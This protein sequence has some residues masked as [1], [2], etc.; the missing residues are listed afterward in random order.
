M[1]ASRSQAALGGT[2][3][4]R[5]VRGKHEDATRTAV[6]TTASKTRRRGLAAPFAR[7]ARRDKS[8][9]ARCTLQ[10]SPLAAGTF[11]FD[12]GERR[13]AA[14]RSLL[15]AARGGARCA[16]R[17]ARNFSRPQFCHGARVERL[18]VAG[19]P[20][21]QR[22]AA[23]AHVRAAEHARAC[24]TR[25]RGP[26]D[27]RQNDRPPPA[28]AAALL[29]AR[30]HLS[31]PRPS[32]PRWLRYAPPPPRASRT[33]TARR[34]RPAPP[35]ATGVEESTAGRRFTTCRGRFMFAPTTSGP[36][37]RGSS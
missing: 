5:V 21:R 12:C 29:Q 23:A 37:T 25:E 20:A 27:P 24:H 4:G 16:A 11:I 28:A 6:K 34:R 26:P 31:L 10:P 13:R 8:F 9:H 32:C 33:S 3:P 18:A 7:H 22:A 36:P 1:A 17:A 30:A 2:A 14:R 35:P 15:C 19:R